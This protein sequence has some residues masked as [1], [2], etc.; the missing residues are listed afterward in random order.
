MEQTKTLVF[1]AAKPFVVPILSGGEN[2][3]RCGF[4][5][6]K[7]GAVGRAPNAPCGTSS[8]VGSRRARTWTCRR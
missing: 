7:N 2:R 3:A 1:D 4:P 5:R 8:G 6:T